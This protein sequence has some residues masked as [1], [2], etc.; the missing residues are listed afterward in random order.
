MNCTILEYSRCRTK[1]EISCAFDVTVNKILTTLF[2][3]GVYRILV[4]QKPTIPKHN[5]IAFNVH[6]DGLAYCASTIFERDILSVKIISK[7][8]KRPGGKG[9]DV[10]FS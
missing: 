8:T 7:H 5:P 6:S 9:I 2:S 3:T 1:N 4:T 10:S